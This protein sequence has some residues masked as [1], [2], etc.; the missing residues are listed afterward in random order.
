VFS[1]PRVLVCVCVCVCVCVVAS[2]TLLDSHRASL[3]LISNEF[4]FELENEGA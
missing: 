4:E 3:T 2:S 1:S